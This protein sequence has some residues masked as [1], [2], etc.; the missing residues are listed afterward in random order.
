MINVVLY[1]PEI[2]Q[3]TGNIMRTCA[4]TGV[5]LHLIKPLGF[6]LDSKY[7]KRSGVNYIPKCEYYVYENYKVDKSTGMVDSNGNPIYLSVI[8]SDGG[9]M[10]PGVY[11]VYWSKSGVINQTRVR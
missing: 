3:N 6:S 9:D 5:K 8:S 10:E 4:G 2:P 7:V 1:Q 11:E